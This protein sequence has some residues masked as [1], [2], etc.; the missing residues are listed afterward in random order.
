[1]DP[2]PDALETSFDLVTRQDAT[3]AAVEA[4]RT[5]VDEVKSRL[6]RVSR[7]AARP[8]I[9]GQSSARPEVKGFVDG[10]LR[11]GRETEPPHRRPRARQR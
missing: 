9:D 11:H 3:D 10:Y 1:M 2:T 7:A 8:V 4:L 6:D 5:D